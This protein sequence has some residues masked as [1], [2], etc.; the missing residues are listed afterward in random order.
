MNR[1]GENYQETHKKPKNKQEIF[2]HLLPIVGLALF[3]FR[4]Y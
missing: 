1:P 4:V 3:F 2:L